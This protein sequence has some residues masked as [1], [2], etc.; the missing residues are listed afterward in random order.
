M[1]QKIT[2]DTLVSSRHSNQR[3]YDAMIEVGIYMGGEAHRVLSEHPQVKVVW[4]T[5]RSD[6]PLEYFHS[7]KDVI[8]SQHL[9]QR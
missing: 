3:G 4:A 6:R 5:S 2:W 7:T 8:M 9:V 1:G